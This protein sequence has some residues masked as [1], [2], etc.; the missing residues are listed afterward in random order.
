MDSISSNCVDHASVK[1]S[2]NT[3]LTSASEPSKQLS[4]RQK[5][6]LENP[7]A[8]LQQRQRE[9]ERRR[10]KIA[11]RQAEV[12][13]A[14]LMGIEVEYDTV[15]RG[16]MEN[17]RAHYQSITK[18]QRGKDKTDISGKSCTYQLESFLQRKPR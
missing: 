16:Q 18:A 7:Q 13:R 2:H 8:Y 10:A 9:N 17:A 5:L 6:K 4:R 14:Q 1:H 3:V 11:L 12:E 15:M